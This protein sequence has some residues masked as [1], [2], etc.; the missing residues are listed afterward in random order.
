MFYFLISFA[1]IVSTLVMTLFSHLVEMIT[2]EKLN[3]AHLINLLIDRS[4]LSMKITRNHILGWLIHCVIGILMVF[5]LFLYQ[6]QNASL[7]MHVHGLCM[8]LAL[9]GLGTLGWWLILSFHPNVPENNWILFF[10]QLMVA[11]LIFALT[12]TFFL[13]TLMA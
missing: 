12:A 11:H 5:G 2:G 1:G 3:E 10:G 9:G 4:K 7:P 13:K 8:G 6:D